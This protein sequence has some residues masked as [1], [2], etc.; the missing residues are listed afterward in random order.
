M[1]HTTN[2]S[3]DDLTDQQDNKDFV[4]NI[5]D[6]KSQIET[7]APSS[8]SLTPVAAVLLSSNSIPPESTVTQ[9]IRSST[10]TISTPNIEASLSNN[11]V[12]QIQQ[13]QRFLGTLQSFAC[14]LSPEIGHAVRSLI[15]TLCV[16]R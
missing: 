7:A 3:D 1:T 8:P 6:I 15:I 13:L 9:G 4:N 2:I 12:K 10:T 5:N 11:K 16:S 14:D